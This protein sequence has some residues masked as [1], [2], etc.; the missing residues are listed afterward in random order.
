MWQIVKCICVHWALVYTFL[1]YWKYFER[2]KEKIQRCGLLLWRKAQFSSK[3]YNKH[4]IALFNSHLKTISTLFTS[5][6]SILSPILESISSL[7]CP[8]SFSMIFS[9]DFLSLVS[10]PQLVKF[11]F[12]MMML[13]ILLSS[14][15]PRVRQAFSVVQM[16]L[17][18]SGV[19]GLHPR[20]LTPPS[21]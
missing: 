9:F 7:Q 4:L 15:V 16:P 19:P 3:D 1:Y 14:N 10:G 12:L 18:H 5:S 17:S 21:W 2:E 8:A 20:I 6:K 11:C 13:T